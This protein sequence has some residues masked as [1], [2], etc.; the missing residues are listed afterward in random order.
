MLIAGCD[1]PRDPEGTLDRAL[2][3]PLRVGVSPNEPWT[4]WEGD[5]PQDRPIGIEPELVEQFAK[6]LKTKVV[7]VHGSETELLTQLEHFGLDV[8]AA[9]LKDDTIW[10]DRVALSRPYAETGDGKHVLAAPPGENEFL[11]RLDKFLARQERAV[12]ARLAKEGP[13]TERATVE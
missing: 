8:V 7:W 4:A 6:E 13:V 9:G 11:L 10:S 12:E 1:F 5:E 3:K 2:S